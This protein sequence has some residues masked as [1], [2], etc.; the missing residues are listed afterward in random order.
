MRECE[1]M[2]KFVQSSRDLRLDL[3]G[4]SQLAS[5]QKLHTCQAS[6]EAEALCQLEHYRIKKVQIGHS[7]SL[8]LELAA[9]SS[10]EAKLLASSILEK[11]T[12]R[13]PN[14]NKYKYP[15]YPQ[16]IESFQKEN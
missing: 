5:C 16:N 9:Q 8:R 6:G 14:T 12:L 4:S 11:L 13:I 10:R 7:V 3:A 1:Q 15:T 2:L